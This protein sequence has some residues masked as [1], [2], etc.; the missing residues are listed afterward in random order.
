MATLDQSQFETQLDTPKEKPDEEIVDSKEEE[1]PSEVKEKKI[2]KK[3]KRVDTKA[4]VILKLQTIDQKYNQ[5]LNSLDELR[6]NHNKLE[7]QSKFTHERLQ[8]AQNRIKELEHVNGQLQY[9]IKSNQE[10]KTI[11]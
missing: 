7:N 1:K 11:V 3:R 8:M 6:K 4:E 9:L 10:K 2:R 5:T